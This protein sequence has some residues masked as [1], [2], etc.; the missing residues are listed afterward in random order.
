M[1]AANGAVTTVETA[2]ALLYQSFDLSFEEV[3][4]I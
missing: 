4:R 2:W 1:M 3:T